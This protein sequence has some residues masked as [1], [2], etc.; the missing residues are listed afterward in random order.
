[1]RL[2]LKVLILLASTPACGYSTGWQLSHWKRNVKC[3]IR[4]KIWWASLSDHGYVS[5][6]TVT[7]TPV[8]DVAQKPLISC[9][10]SHIKD[11]MWTWIDFRVLWSSGLNPEKFTP[12]THSSAPI[13]LCVNSVRWLRDSAILIYRDPHSSRL[14]NM[15]HSLNTSWPD[16]THTC[17]VSYLLMPWLIH[18][19]C[20]TWTNS[21]WLHHAYSCYMIFIA[22]CNGLNM[23]TYVVTCIH[24][25]CVWHTEPF[26]YVG[27]R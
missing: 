16:S 7:C 27:N 12:T 24:F 20:T 10:A 19:Y 2:F 4:S 22:W 13:T 23:S 11:C 14:A 9:S 17:D 5:L 15:S 1:M 21:H 3:Q 8:S 25:I 18:L 6:L 26:K